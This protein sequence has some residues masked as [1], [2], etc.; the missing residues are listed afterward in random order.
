[1]AGAGIEKARSY[2]ERFGGWTLVFG[3]FVPGI[4]NLIGFT[5]GMMRLRIR[6]FAPLAY[7]GAIISSIAC[8]G[9]GYFLGAQAG[10]VLTSAGRVAVIT[11]SAAALLIARN[12]IRNGAPETS[13]SKTR[14][15]AI[16]GSLE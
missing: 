15:P 1:V 11:A 2:F 10:W 3:Y 14:T 13:K 5:S 6:Y 4:R 7:L 16:I 8:V 12:A 9:A